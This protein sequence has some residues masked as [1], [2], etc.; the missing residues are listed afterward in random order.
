[1]DTLEDFIA[2]RPPTA[3][4]PLLGLTV[5][6]VE[7]SRFASEALRLM[8]L[9]S[10]ARIRR[11]DTLSHARRHLGVYRPSAVIVDLG[12]PDGSGADLI[13]DLAGASPR[14]DVILGMS[15]DPGGEQAAMAAGADGFLDK[16]IAGLAAFQRAILDHLT[17]ERRPAGPRAVAEDAVQ[18]DRIALHDD[19]VMAAAALT[20]PHRDGTLA[21]LTQF[22]GSLARLTEDRDL[23]QAVAAIRDTG[24]GQGQLRRL[25]AVIDDRLDRTANL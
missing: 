7:D 1:M 22:L 17:P 11:A 3:Q 8:C 18:P 25:S 15:G 16:P 21:Y 6:V 10:G 23:D 24:T 20:H 2:S 13:K 9:R 5:L 12:L 14:V 19:L 4:R